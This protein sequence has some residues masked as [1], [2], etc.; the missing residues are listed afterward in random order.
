MG[1]QRVGHD[2]V[3]NTSTL[4][5]NNILSNTSHSPGTVLLRLQWP[6]K[7][8]ALQAC[9]LPTGEVSRRE[10][11]CPQLTGEGAGAPDRNQVAQDL[12]LKKEITNI[13]NKS[14]TSHNPNNTKYYLRHGIFCIMKPKGLH[15]KIKVKLVQG[16]DRRP[17]GLGNISHPLVWSQ[18]GQKSSSLQGMIF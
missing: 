4:F 17:W 9:S 7:P 6:F 15:L 14:S 5:H 10:T 13:Q 3:T 18:C 16:R 1:R 11:H 8:M 2:R 12:T